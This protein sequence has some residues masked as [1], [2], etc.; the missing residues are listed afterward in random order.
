MS[1]PRN[2]LGSDRHA[3]VAEAIREAERRTS[4]EI[5]C[6]LASQVSAYRDVGALWAAVIALLCPLVLPLLGL[7]PAALFHFGRV[8][9]AAHLAAAELAAAGVV[10]SVVLLQLLVFGA[11]MLLWEWPVVRRALTPHSIRQRRVRHAAMQQFLAHGLHVT[12][13]RTGVLIFAARAD[14]QVE[15]V[16][17]AGIHAKTP[18]EV[19]G[20]AAAALADGLRRGDPAAGYIAAVALCGEVLA[21]HFP[22]RDGNPNELP[23]KLLEI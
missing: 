23:D 17:D 3:Q 13:D 14:H 10:V 1:G 5:F 11:V 22:P 18:P 7:D 2:S 19:W 16:A 12:E 6:V 4:G 20:E 21:Q 8:W 9:S 15:I